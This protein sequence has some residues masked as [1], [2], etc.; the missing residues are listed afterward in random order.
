VRQGADGGS[1]GRKGGGADR[2]ILLKWSQPL[3]TWR[4]FSTEKTLGTPFA[5][6]LIRFLSLSFATTPL[7]PANKG[8][9]V[10]LLLRGQYKRKKQ[11]AEKK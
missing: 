6:M 5:R 8:I 7:R 2:K 10:I 3:T 1:S 9:V 4:L 11:R